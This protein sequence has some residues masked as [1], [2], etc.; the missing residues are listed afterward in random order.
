MHLTIDI[1]NTRGKWALFE[2]D[3]LVRSGNLAEGLPEGW[4]NWKTMVCATGDTDL[5]T[6]GLDR[7][8]RLTA[9]TPL[10]IVLDY[11]T[12]ETLGADRIAAACGAQRVGRAGSAKVIVDAGT[13]ITIDLLD[14]EGAYHG[15]A[16]LP[17]IA[18]KFR[19]LHTFTAKLPLLDCSIEKGG[20]YVTGRS[21][22][23]SMAAGV[24][25]ATRYEVEGFVRHYRKQIDNVEVILT[26][27]DAEQLIGEGGL[28]AEECRVV[29]QLVMIGMNEI[30]K[31]MA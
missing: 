24:L 21:T 27:G 9:D 25:T 22:H 3:Q 19:A 20:H 1:G 30:L 15:G 14:G 23:E 26:G 31:L 10:P 28:A 12:P 4:R 17:G 6:L 7:S 11:A 16:I 18:M 13:C 2:G 8:Y 5:N 29:P